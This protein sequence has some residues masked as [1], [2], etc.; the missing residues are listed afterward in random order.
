M[1]NRFKP[2]TISKLNAEFNSCGSTKQFHEK[3]RSDL[4]TPGYVIGFDWLRRTVDG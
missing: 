4:F 2:D 3:D 1:T